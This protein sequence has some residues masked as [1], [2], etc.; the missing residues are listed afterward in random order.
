MQHNERTGQ[1]IVKKQYY[2][3]LVEIIHG[4]RKG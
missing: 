3:K 2:K 4:E 1:L